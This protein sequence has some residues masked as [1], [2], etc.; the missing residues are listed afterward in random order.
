M[1]LPTTTSRCF[2]MVMFPLE[3]SLFFFEKKNQKT[4]AGLR[5]A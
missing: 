2:A 5:R 4:F 1:P 3:E